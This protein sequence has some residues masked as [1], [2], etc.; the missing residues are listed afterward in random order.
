MSIVS[1]HDLDKKIYLNNCEIFSE[2]EIEFDIA[3][4]TVLVYDDFSNV[5]PALSPE[6][7]D[8][9]EDP[10][11]FILG[12][13]VISFIELDIKKYNSLLSDFVEKYS[14]YH[15]LNNHVD[16]YDIHAFVSSLSHHEINHIY[17]NSL[18]IH[19]LMR[20]TMTEFYNLMQINPFTIQEIHHF[21][22]AISCQKLEPKEINHDFD[23]SFSR[24]LEDIFTRT[25]HMKSRL[26]CEVHTNDKS[27]ITKVVTG[28]RYKNTS[29]ISFCVTELFKMLESGIQIRICKNCNRFF[30]P[31]NNHTADYCTRICNSKGQT[32]KE[33]GAQKAYK[34]KVKSNPILKE[35]EKAYKRNYAKVSRGELSRDAFEKW[36]ANAVTK[37]EE[38]IKAFDQTGDLEIV[39]NFK[40]FL[41]NR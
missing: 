2:N 24:D 28:V 21:L 3:N 38:A 1:N 17:F 27:Q 30:I 35:Y 41:G 13:S 4:K 12:E 11:A 8:G 37:R 22:T 39:N 18:D 14:E 20:L 19:S 34:A 26:L 5:I 6:V 40:F 10:E 29:P 31:Q 32:C 15:S 16:T 33:I 25:P 7:T 23:H 36:S 9:N